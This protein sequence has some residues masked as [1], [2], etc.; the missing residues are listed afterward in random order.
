MGLQNLEY[1]AALA[2]PACTTQATQVCLC[3]EIPLF[4]FSHP[5]FFFFCSKR[6]QMS[7]LDL[8]GR[9]ECVCCSPQS[10]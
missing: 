6:I 5:L 9:S 10:W 8:S 7:D 3:P 1:E 2:R 4:P